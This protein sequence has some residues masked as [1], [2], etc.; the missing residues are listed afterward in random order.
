VSP[1]LRRLAERIDAMSL[2]ERLLIFL[3]VAALVV[4]T[5]D[6]LLIE[7]SFAAAKRIS[8]EIARQQAEISSIDK[9]LQALAVAARSDPNRD[10]R[11]RL[12]VLRGELGDLE[13][14]I[15]GE[16][17]R[18]TSP[19]QMRSLVE[20]L[21]A[22][23]PGISLVELRTLPK[24]PITA[25]VLETVGQ[26]LG[27]SA[28]VYR[29]GLEVTVSGA[30]LDL[31][32]YLDELERLPHQIRWTTLALDASAHPHVVLKFTLQTRSLD[33]AWMNV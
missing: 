25:R 30:Y 11:A 17:A 20:S 27:G 24:G 2:R 9:Q 12:E 4:T 7:P 14:R 8:L 19:E 5:L 26:S 21:I 32:A 3:A 13:R 28:L 22:R 15:A 33:A 31:L 16:Q 29:H 23:N 1:T 10:K 18:V 6:A